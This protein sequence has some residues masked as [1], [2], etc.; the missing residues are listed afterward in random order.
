MRKKTNQTIASGILLLV[1]IY[2]TTLHNETGFIHYLVCDGKRTS[3]IWAYEPPGRWKPLP[4]AG[5]VRVRV[6]ERG[7]PVSMHQTRTK[8]RWRS[9]HQDPARGTLYRP[10]GASLSER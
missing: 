7:G 8:H 9:I 2:S 3:W 4:V 6:P 1:E 5:D 10:C